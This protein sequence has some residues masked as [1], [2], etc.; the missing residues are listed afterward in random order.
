MVT[1]DETT[2]GMTFAVIGVVFS[3][4]WLVLGLYGINTLRDVRQRLDDAESGDD[5]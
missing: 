5:S 3:I 4:A 2:I 1:I